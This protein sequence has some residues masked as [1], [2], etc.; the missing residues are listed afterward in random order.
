VTTR[1]LI[2]A[3]LVALSRTSLGHAAEPPRC[4]GAGR[5]WGSGRLIA[6]GAFA[7][8]A[9]IASG[10][11]SQIASLQ[12]ANAAQQAQIAALK[13]AQAQANAAN[14]TR[15][16]A[17]VANLRVGVDTSYGY[18]SGVSYVQGMTITSPTV[19]DGA[20]SCDTGRFVPVTPQAP[21]HGG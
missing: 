21:P 18:G 12:T 9:V 2:C 19:K 11:S 3:S 14:Q 16:Q 8:L 15:S 20:V 1:T 7:F 4:R 17:A 13:S 5:S 10:Q 6:A